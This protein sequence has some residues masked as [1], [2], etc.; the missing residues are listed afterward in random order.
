MKLEGLG[1]ID[2]VNLRNYP[3]MLSQAFD[4][5]AR[6]IA[7]WKIVLRRLIDSIALHLMLSINELIN[8]DLQKEI[9]N[10]LLSPSG[11]G[12]E[13]LLESLHLFLGREKS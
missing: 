4:L 6:M 1:D 11:G 10:D 7:Y 2:V 13:R 12:I 8:N 5:K 9:C 3:H